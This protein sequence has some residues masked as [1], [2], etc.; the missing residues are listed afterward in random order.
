MRLEIR[1]RGLE[2][3]A[4][5]Q[6][7]IRRRLGFALGRFGSRVGRVTVHLADADAQRGGSDTHCRIVARLLPAGR[8]CVEV[9]D[10]DL[11]TALNRAA[12]R[13]G[14]AVCREFMRRHDV[15]RNRGR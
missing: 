1:S 4:A 10:T 6:D 9:T 5:W 7:S 11:T 15:G 8:V 2:L 14:P 13:I 3:C 12:Q